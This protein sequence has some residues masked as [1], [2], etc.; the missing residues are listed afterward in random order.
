MKAWGDTMASSAV[1]LPFLAFLLLI[2]ASQTAGQCQVEQSCSWESDTSAATTA[3]AQQGTTMLQKPIRTP[4]NAE[5]SK[6]LQRRG[7]IISKGAAEAHEEPK[8]LTLEEDVQSTPKLRAASFFQVEEETRAAPHADAQEGATESVN[9][10][11]PTPA[12]EA[13]Q[14][15][16]DSKSVR[17]SSS[18]SG[19]DSSANASTI[20]L[21]GTEQGHAAAGSHGGSS[22]VLVISNTVADAVGQEGSLGVPIWLKRCFLLGFVFAAV[23]LA[24]AAPRSF[25]GNSVATLIRSRV[26]EMRTVSGRELK[27]MFAVERSSSSGDAARQEPQEMAPGLL[28]RLHGRVVAARESQGKLQAPLSGRPC[29]VYSASV[30]R[31]RLDGVHQP[32]IAFHASSVDFEIEVEDEMETPVRLRVSSQDVL[33]FDMNPGRFACDQTLADAAPALRSFV[34]AHHMKGTSAS[35]E[36]MHHVDPGAQGLLDFRECALLLGQTVTC[37][38]EVC[39]DRDGGLSLQPW[40]PASNLDCGANDASA[41]KDA[42][43]TTIFAS[44]QQ[45]LGKPA[46]AKGQ[47]PRDPLNSHVAI[48]DDPQLYSSV[49]LPELAL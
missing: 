4:S 42:A 46:P 33:L 30:S 40:R 43:L 3:A 10:P 45:M 34:L 23:T 8:A 16:T 12:P 49:L 5:S 14:A 47:A 37:I 35:S 24:W 2:S 15:I 9:A 27:S 44:W 11:A 41:S 1:P 13:Q 19:G 20:L 25:R 26:E 22:N 17:P 29:V 38:G 48:S 7:A 32:P 36:V 39:R 18:S 21:S 6:V 28:M 31:Q